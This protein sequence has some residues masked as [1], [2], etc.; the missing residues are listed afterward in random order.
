VG[1]LGTFDVPS[2][3]DAGGGPVSPTVDEFYF[4][5]TGGTARKKED[6]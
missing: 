2:N 5:S 4:L 3:D 6:A 1:I